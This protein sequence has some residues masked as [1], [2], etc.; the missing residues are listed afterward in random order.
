MSAKSKR[1]TKQLRAFLSRP[2]P[3]TDIDKARL[4]AIDALF[5]KLKSSEKCYV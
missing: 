1:R 5:S 4:Q 2:K 3:L